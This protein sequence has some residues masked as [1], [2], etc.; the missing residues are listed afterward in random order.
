LETSDREVWILDFEGNRWGGSFSGAGGDHAVEVSRLPTRSDVF[1]VELRRNKGGPEQLEL[2]I[3]GI[4]WNWIRSTVHILLLRTSDLSS[5]FNLVLLITLI[6]YCFQL[7]QVINSLIA[8][9]PYFAS[10]TPLWRNI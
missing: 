8:S 7:S 6:L 10:G 5:V 9:T 1:N 2:D 4:D 3:E